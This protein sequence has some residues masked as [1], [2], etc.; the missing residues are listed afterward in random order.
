[1]AI[2][3]KKHIGIKRKIDHFSSLGK[4]WGCPALAQP[5]DPTWLRHCCFPWRRCPP[6]SSNCIGIILNFVSNE[7]VTRIKN[8]GLVNSSCLALLKFLLAV[9][10]RKDEDSTQTALHVA[11]PTNGVHPRVQKPAAIFHK[12]F[13]TLPR[14]RANSI[15][16]KPYPVCSNQKMY[17]VPY[18]H[19]LTWGQS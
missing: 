2:K 13:F 12:P 6:S 17:P 3:N 9:H 11:F 4:V 8:M 15:W 16:R 5:H 18:Q 10:I 7:Y 1:M 19:T 14:L